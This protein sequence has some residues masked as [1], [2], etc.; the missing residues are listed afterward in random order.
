[1]SSLA[2]AVHPE[3]TPGSCRGW[4][5]EHLG[6]FHVLA[7]INS[8]M[9]IGVHLSF[10]T[11]VAFLFYWLYHFELEFSPDICPVVGLLVMKQLYFC[12]FKKTPYCVHSGCTNL[13]T[14]QQCWK[15][16]FSLQPLK[17][18]LFVDFLM[19][20]IL[21]TVRLSHCS[22]DLHFSNNMQC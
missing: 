15:F 10:C 1:M 2:D 22:F 6:C 11:S 8:A 14:H 7:I 19:I 20:S 16:P 9:N 5:H 21:T 18:L 4:R 17:I 13:H 3:G 12:F